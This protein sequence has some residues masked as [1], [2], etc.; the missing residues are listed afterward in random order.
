MKIELGTEITG[1]FGAMHP[2]WI[3]KVV[4]IDTTMTPECKVKWD[5][6]AGGHTW[7]LLSEIRDDYFDPKLPGIGYFAVDTDHAWDWVKE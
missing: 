3:G 2:E 6:P 1:C 5:G 4:A 7:M